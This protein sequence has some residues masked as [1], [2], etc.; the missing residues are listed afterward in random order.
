VAGS[1]LKRLLRAYRDR[2]DLAFRRAA[3]EII[4]E[5]EAKHHVQLARD[6]RR[7]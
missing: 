5:E 2:D 4:E 7:L 6:L 1:Q 3:V